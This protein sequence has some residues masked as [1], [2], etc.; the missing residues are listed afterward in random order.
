MSTEERTGANYTSGCATKASASLHQV[1][2]SLP[3]LHKADV[4]DQ[5]PY[6]EIDLSQKKTPSSL[7]P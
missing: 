3:I 6:T 4:L 5:R 7:H 1:L 2:D